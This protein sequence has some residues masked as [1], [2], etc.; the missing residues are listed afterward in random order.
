MLQMMMMIRP[1]LR[2]AVRNEEGVTAVEYAI[3]ACVVAGVVLGLATPLSTALTAG[4][5]AIQAKMTVATAG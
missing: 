1:F 2:R 3:L 4:F 5:T